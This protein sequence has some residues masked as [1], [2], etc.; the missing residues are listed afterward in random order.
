MKISNKNLCQNTRTGMVA[1][2]YQY[3]NLIDQINEFAGKNKK[4]FIN[5]LYLMASDLCVEKE[6]E[7]ETDDYMR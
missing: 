7:I 1:E 6:V 5:I 2:L 4:R 3:D